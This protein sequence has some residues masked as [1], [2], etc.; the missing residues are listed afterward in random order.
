MSPRGS[1]KLRQ[2]TLNNLTNAGRPEISICDGNY[3]N[4]GE[5]YFEHTYHGVE[6]QANYAQDTLVNLQQLWGRPVHIETVLDG[7]VTVI[8]YDGTQHE[9]ETGDAWEV[10]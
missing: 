4:R 1:F 5:L 2:E 9:M 7:M 6:L 10:E 8:S 3:K